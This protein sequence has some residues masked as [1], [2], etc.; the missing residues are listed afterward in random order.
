MKIVITGS[1]AFDYLMSFPGRFAEMLL[2]DQ[3]QH[4][5][6]SFLVDSLKRQR[7]G[8]APNI[9][10]TMALLNGRPH[11]MATAGQDFAEYRAWL[12]AQGVDTSAIVAIEDEFTASFF[13]NTDLDQNQIASFYTGAMARARDLTFAKFAPDADLAIISPN[14]PDAMRNYVAECKQLNI[15]YI[16]D[17]SQ[18]TIRLSGEDLYAGLD[19]CFLLSVNDYEF[20]L[21]QD[22]TGLNEDQIL[23]KV[24]GLLV[25]KGSSGSRLVMDGQ[26]YHIPVVPPH[27]VVEPTGAGDAFR[28]GLMR[29]MQL[30]LPWD[31]AGRMG[32]LAATYVLEQLGTQ[33]HHYTPAEFIARYRENF[34]DHGALDA[35]LA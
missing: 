25:T 8:T 7:G 10:Y 5:S 11:I 33:N 30:G 22:R 9:A 23:Q 3:L 26:E 35:L 6:L 15:P 2:A 31:V 19:G 13:V 24:G 18:Q 34:D 32:A 21:I 29:G 14:D 16:Y 4:V 20:N 28:A 1:I 17:S 12:E 27:K